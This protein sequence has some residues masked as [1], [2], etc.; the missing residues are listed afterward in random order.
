MNMRPIFKLAV[1]EPG[2][3]E[4]VPVIEDAHWPLGLTSFGPPNPG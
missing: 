2:G 3:N 1:P 4:N